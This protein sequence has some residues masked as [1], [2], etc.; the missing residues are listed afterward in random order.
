MVLRWTVKKYATGEENMPVFDKKFVVK[1]LVEKV[2]KL[3]DDLQAEFFS[4]L[5]KK[6]SANETLWIYKQYELR[7]ASNPKAKESK[8]KAKESKRKQTKAKENKAKQ[9]K[10]EL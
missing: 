6:I 2:K 3:P 9:R 1:T 10:A 4:W 5:E 8:A 7:R